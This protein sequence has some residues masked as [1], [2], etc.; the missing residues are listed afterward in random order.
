[1]NI[2][3]VVKKE[4]LRYKIEASKFEIL[5]NKNGILV[6]RLTDLGYVL[7]MFFSSYSREIDVYRLFNRLGIKTARVIEFKENSILL[8]DIKENEY[9]RLATEE[10]LKNE[11]VI[12]ALAR[13]YQNIHVKGYEYFINND[14]DFYSGVSEM[15]LDEIKDLKVK[16]GYEDS[17]F[18]QQLIDV[19]PLVKDYVKQNRTFNY[20]EF[21]YKNLVV[22]KDLEE[23][24][25]IDFSHLGWGLSY[26]DHQNIISN[27]EFDSK[28]V[29]ILERYLDVN[30]L[31]AYID[32]V[33]AVIYS[34]IS[35]FH[36]LEFP[37]TAQSSYDA[38]MSGQVKEDL[39]R[40][41]EEFRSYEEKEVL[42]LVDDTLLL[43][44]AKV[45]DIELLACWWAD[46]EVME[47]A[48]FP[49][50]LKIDQEELAAKYV[51][52]NAS[53]IETLRL[54]I[55]YDGKLIGET[56]YRLI[57]RRVYDF[58][59]KLCN[60]E[61]QNRGIGTQ[62]TNL[63]L[64]FLINDLQARRV[65]LST[66]PENIRARKVYEKLGFVETGTDID[67]WTDQLGN[68]RSSVH[69]EL[70]IDAFKRER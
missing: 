22:S 8:E 33:Y 36:F 52:N 34:L 64:T 14:I 24:Y 5:S 59:I 62:A 40:L 35:G 65:V 48:G 49:N 60:K 45:S 68:K 19:L 41:V 9:Y 18:W 53:G 70:D 28:H 47:H 32:K 56:H 54:M 10:D 38:L 25:M 43:R 69:Y 23:A 58:G 15:T 37:E 57:G 1:M 55:E 44:N 13:W 3:Q 21:T 63:L 6:V 16:T 51:I 42:T 66:T 20:N 11:K 26:F 50:G 46:G 61:Y 12:E 17:D 39:Q 67:S 4:L 31:D 29:T 7:K 30:P 2:L 27:K